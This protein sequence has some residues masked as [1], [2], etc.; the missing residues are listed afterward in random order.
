MPN[1]L[2]LPFA[3]AHLSQ[4]ININEQVLDL[5]TSH[6]LPAICDA[7]DDEQHGSSALCDIQCLQVP[8]RCFPPELQPPSEL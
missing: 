2:T 8:R 4:D 5:Y 3:P 7:G 6:V 1:I